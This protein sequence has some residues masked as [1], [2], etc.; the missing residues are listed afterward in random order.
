VLEGEDP[1]AISREE[2]NRRLGERQRELMRQAR[3][4]W[5]LDFT[6]YR[7]AVRAVFDTPAYAAPPVTDGG[8]PDR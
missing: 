1:A 7:R 8:A 4:V 3:S 5:D 6:D 2:M